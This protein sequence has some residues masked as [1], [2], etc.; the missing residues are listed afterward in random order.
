MSSTETNCSTSSTFDIIALNAF[1]DN[2]IWALTNKKADSSTVALVDPG[3]ADVCISFLE[4]HQLILNTIL[5]THHHADHTGG[6]KDLIAYCH[7]K[8]WPL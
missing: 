8:Q 3:D 4:Q 6:I 5:I 2:Y 1:S 7:H